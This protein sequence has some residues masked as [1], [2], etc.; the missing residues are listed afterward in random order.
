MMKDKH[1]QHMIG[2]IERNSL[3]MYEEKEKK[4]AVTVYSFV[5]LLNKFLL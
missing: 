3:A 1:E 4:V 5:V 2:N